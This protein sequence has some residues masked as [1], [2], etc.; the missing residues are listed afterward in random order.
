MTVRFI[1][2]GLLAENSGHGYGLRNQFVHRLGHFRKINEGQLYTE[3]AKM[4]KE[5]LIEREVEVPEKGPARKV[6][7]ITPKGRRLFTEWL[8]S[9]AYEDEGILYDFIQGYP[10]FSKCTFFKHMKPQEIVSKIDTQVSII[11]RKKKA[12]EEILVKMSERKVDRFRIRILEFGLE[13]MV[14]RIRWLRTMKKDVG[15]EASI[16]EA[17]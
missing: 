4:E 14:H 5:G 1:L 17:T 16:Q 6:L 13:E 12:Y 9:G 15:A 10:F 2:L 11:E 8:F 3:L 7:H